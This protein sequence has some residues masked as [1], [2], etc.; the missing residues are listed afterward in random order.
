MIHGRLESWRD[1]VEATPRLEK[2]FAWIAEHAD[3]A[4]EPG[5]HE[6]D[7]K[8]IFVDVHNYTTNP[9]EGGLYEAHD[10][11]MDIQFIA[12][13]SE[14]MFYT[15][16]DGLAVNTPYMDDKDAILYEMAEGDIPS[17]TPTAGEFVVFM[18]EVAHMPGRHPE[19]GPSEVA[20]YVVKVRVC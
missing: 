10:I 7:G 18:P 19:S 4:L 3:G 12:K 11:Y 1:A 9:I 16:R 15:G 8:D 20:K 5:R 2:A 13:G 14:R 17:V 6:V